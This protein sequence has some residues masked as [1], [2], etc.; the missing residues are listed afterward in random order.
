MTKKAFI[1]LEGMCYE[2]RLRTP[3]Y[4]GFERGRPRGHLTALCLPL[5]RGTGGGRASLCSLSPQTGHV[6]RHKAVSGDVQVG[7]R[8]G[9]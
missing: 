6:A 4:S 7:T 1:S 3:G 2:E 5:R 9:C 8:D